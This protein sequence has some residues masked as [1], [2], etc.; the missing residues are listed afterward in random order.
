MS[1]AWS[2]WKAVKVVPFH[3]LSVTE[4]SRSHGGL[5]QAPLRAVEPNEEEDRPLQTEEAQQQGENGKRVP[6]P[7]IREI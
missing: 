7:R 3:Q 5:S 6:L 2:S 1:F 4:L